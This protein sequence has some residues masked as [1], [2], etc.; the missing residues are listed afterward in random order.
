MR[1]GISLWLAVAWRASKVILSA[2]SGARLIF[3]LADGCSCGV[4]PRKYAFK[5]HK[6]KAHRKAM[7]KMSDAIYFTLETRSY[8]TWLTQNLLNVIYYIILF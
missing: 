4:L 2:L 3:T 5:N 1:W 8:K 7:R 6:L